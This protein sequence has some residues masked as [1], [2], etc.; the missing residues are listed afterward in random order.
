[1][2]GFDAVRASLP[3]D[4]LHV[5]GLKNI[6]PF[7]STYQG[8][9][10]LIHDALPNSHI[11]GLSDSATLLHQMSETAGRVRLP[12]L[13]MQYDTDSRLVG[14]IEEEM[15]LADAV[16]VLLER[17]SAIKEGE[18][19]QRHYI[20]W[21]GLPEDGVGEGTEYADVMELLKVPNHLPGGN[22]DLVMERNLWTGRS[23]TSHLHFDGADNLHYVFAGCKHV[24][25]YSPWDLPYLYPR[26]P[27]HDK[28][29]NFT[30]VE[31]SLFADPSTHPKFADSKRYEVTVKAGECLFI[32][33]GW[34]HEFLT[35]TDL[36]VSCNVWFE[37]PTC[38]NMR[39]S[40]LYLHSAL[41]RNL[42][43]RKG[44]V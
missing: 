30:N 28:A 9:P 33:K 35:D 6:C 38:A 24:H 20:Q 43:G 11:D 18:D 34:Y 10:V 27:D 17:E 37:A 14:S 1:M 3:L 44:V 41:Y 25:L 36:T 22:L 16:T 5:V 13:C 21:R 31:S 23:R 39:P 2:E 8:T 26:N 4:I 7:S 12:L 19:H 32:P 29:A 42:I 15:S 40:C